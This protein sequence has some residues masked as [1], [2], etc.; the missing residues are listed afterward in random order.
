MRALLEYEPYKCFYCI[1][2]GQH[3]LEN[4]QI[5]YVKFISTNYYD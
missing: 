5:D 2:Y 1:T 3:V 4:R